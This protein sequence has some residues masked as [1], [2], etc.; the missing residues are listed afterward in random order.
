MSAI[1]TINF[2]ISA[3][4]TGNFTIPALTADVRNG[5]QLSTPAGPAD[6]FQ[7]QRPHHCTD[8]NSGNEQS[9]S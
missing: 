6:R 1:V 8:V 7:A 9:P 2:T 4:K 5:Q 3:Q